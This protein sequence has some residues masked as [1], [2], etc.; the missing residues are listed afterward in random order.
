M[1]TKELDALSLEYKRNYGTARRDLNV[2]D[3]MN[4][5]NGEGVICVFGPGFSEEV[6]NL[7]IFELCVTS[8]N[9]ADTSLILHN[10]I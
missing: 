10:T 3:L 7:P 4:N 6:T 5:P 8:D 2:T 1:I 9:R